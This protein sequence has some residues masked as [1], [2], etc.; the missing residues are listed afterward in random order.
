LP[1]HIPDLE[2]HIWQ[3]DGADILPYRWDCFQFWGG[4]LRVEKRFDLFMEGG[5]AGIVEAEEDYR[6]FCCQSL[7]ARVRVLGFRKARRT[8]KVKGLFTLFARR[9]EI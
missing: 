1:A 9:K 6:V 3:S 8:R 2:V 4:V 7:L 5:F